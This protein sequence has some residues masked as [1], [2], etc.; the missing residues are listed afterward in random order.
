MRE[1]VQLLAPIAAAPP[2]E[3]HYIAELHQA[4]AD[5]LW[6]A[7][8]RPAAREEARAA[9]AAWTALGE[10]FEGQRAQTADWIAKHR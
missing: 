1:A 2:L 10:P 7:G 3:P 4:R 5:A 6:S 8:D 9:L